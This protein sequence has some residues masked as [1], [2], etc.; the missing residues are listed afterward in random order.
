MCR[1]YLQSGPIE[2]LFDLDNACKKAPQPGY[3]LMMMRMD[4]LKIFCS[5]IA[6][7]LVMKPKGS[8]TVI[9]FGNYVS[10]RKLTKANISL[11]CR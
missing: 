6:L 1:R 7:I 4:L 8:D 10:L 9:I 2:I 11:N 3:E 5:I